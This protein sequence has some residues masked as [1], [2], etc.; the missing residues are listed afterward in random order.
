MN[1]NLL[2]MISNHTR[3]LQTNTNYYRETNVYQRFLYSSFHSF[4]K[5]Y[6]KSTIQKINEYRRRKKYYI[7]KIST[8]KYQHFVQPSFKTVSKNQ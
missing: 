1:I 6:M 5:Y 4:R 2:S 8:F 3:S 7:E